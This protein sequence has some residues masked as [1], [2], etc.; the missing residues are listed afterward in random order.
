MKRFLLLSFVIMSSICANAQWKIG[1][2]TFKNYFLYLGGTM[3][4]PYY[5]EDR[6][7]YF[8][9]TENSDGTCT[10]YGLDIFWEP[11]S[12]SSAFFQHVEFT[13]YYMADTFNSKRRNIS[14]RKGPGPKF[15]VAGKI[16]S[17]NTI[18][19]QETDND[20]LKVYSQEEYT[21]KSK[22]LYSTSINIEVFSPDNLIYLGY[23]HKDNVKSIDIT[24]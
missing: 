21:D 23:I 18:V 19:Y 20:W 13:G 3:E 2:M 16:D 5:D 15:P 6:V 11:F 17:N 14:I 9:Y 22:G 7:I 1:K 4:E 10:E 12:R 8:P 24:E